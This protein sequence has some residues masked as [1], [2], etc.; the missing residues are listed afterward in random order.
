MLIDLF[1]VGATLYEI[2]WLG[3]PVVVPFTV[4]SYEQTTGGIFVPFKMLGRCT[5]NESDVGTILF[6]NQQDAEIAVKGMIQ[7]D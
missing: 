1:V 5:F 6:T 3:E 4:S 2:V 7:Y